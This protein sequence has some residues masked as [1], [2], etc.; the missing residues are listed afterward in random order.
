M[1]GSPVLES[2]SN[3][4]SGSAILQAEM[5]EASD[6]IAL[7]LAEE[8]AQAAAS[9]VLIRITKVWRLKSSLKVISRH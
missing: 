1:Q 8:G 3:P 9:P 7:Q 5:L 6:M 4:L 2:A